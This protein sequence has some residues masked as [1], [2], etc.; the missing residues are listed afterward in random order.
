MNAYLR[1]FL[2]EVAFFAGFLFV[3]F[4]AVFFTALRRA[5]FLLAVLRAAFFLAGIGTTSSPKCNVAF[6]MKCMHTHDVRAMNCFPS[7]KH[8]IHTECVPSISQ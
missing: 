6:R 7:N 5:G 3:V 4:L 1:F 2:R 8:F